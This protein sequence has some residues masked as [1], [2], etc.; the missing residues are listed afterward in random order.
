[1]SIMYCYKHDRHV[2]TDYDDCEECQ[3]EEINEEMKFDEM[4]DN[5]LQDTLSN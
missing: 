2:D 1:M 3:Q 4:R 5:E